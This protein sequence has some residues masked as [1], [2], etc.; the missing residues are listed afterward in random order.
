MLTTSYCST[1]SESCIAAATYWIRLT[2]LAALDPDI[3]HT[4]QSAVKCPSPR[5]LFFWEDP[6]P[7]LIH[8]FLSPPSPYLKRHLDEFIRFSTDAHHHGCWGL[9]DSQTV[10]PPNIGNNRPQLMIATTRMRTNI[11][12]ALVPIKFCINS[13]PG[14]ASPGNWLRHW[15]SSN[16]MSKRELMFISPHFCSLFWSS[17]RYLLIRCLR[18]GYLFYV[19]GPGCSTTHNYPFSEKCCLRT[20]ALDRQLCIF[21]R[22]ATTKPECGNNRGAN[23]VLQ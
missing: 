13:L 17:S 10:R 8:C 18:P 5:F 11:V 23:R 4:L 14:W 21:G 6:T 2:I 22:P 20:V 9:A 3:P 15:R 1:D 19:Y 16:I 7:H 12:N